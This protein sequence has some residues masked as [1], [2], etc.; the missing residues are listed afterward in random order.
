MVAEGRR[1][2]RNVQRVAKL[3]VT[4]S[5]FAAFLVLSIGLTPTAYPLLPRQLTLAASL[6]IGIPG[7][8]LALA[9]S[10]GRYSSQGFLRELARF[11]LPAGTAAGLGVL[12]SYGFALNVLD[13]RLTAARTVAV[14][15][16][17]IVG[18]Y[19]IL[20]LEVS[21]RVR[22]AAV[23]MLCLVLLI[24]YLLVLLVPFAREFF[25]LASP[26]IAV[27]VPALAGAALAIA[28]LAVLDDRFIPG[29]S[30]DTASALGGDA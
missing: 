14:T 10:T 28:G 3:F 4:K 7:F 23:S 30:A 13:L 18:L 26:S 5:A 21:G 9:P 27:V 15:V 20:A 12:S 16:L 6:T 2:L 11:A 22:G 25:L 29:R 8:F 19:L 24:G 17:V 1:I